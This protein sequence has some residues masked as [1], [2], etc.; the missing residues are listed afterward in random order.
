M[1]FL[2]P[3]TIAACV[4]G[5][6][7]G[8]ALL[9]M[10]LRYCVPDH[11]RHDESKDVVKLVLGLIATLAAIVLGLLISSAN[12]FYDT[13]R[14]EMQTLSVKVVQLDHALSKYGPEA[15]GAR[16]ALRAAVVSAH[17]RI[18]PAD[19]TSGSL[20][21]TQAKNPPITAFETQMQNLKPAT[22]E[23]RLSWGTA[24]QIAGEIAAMRMMISAQ[25]GNSLS[26]PFL[27]ILT[28]WVSVL[29]LGFGLLA[30]WNGT[31]AAT[32]LVGSIAVASATFLI[33]ELNQPYSGMMRLADTPLRLA[34][35]QISR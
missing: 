12:G 3:I 26:W 31:V 8:A 18:W 23:Q 28:F 34:I 6:T 2:Q 5:C 33:L 9:G 19:G 15:D 4:V 25:I 11:H 27:F 35:E 21:P 20:E 16:A 29:F 7:F 10:F 14:D 13:Q 24:N 1:A 17:D 22:E 30:E 32:L